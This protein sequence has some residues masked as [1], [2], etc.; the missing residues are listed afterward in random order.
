MPGTFKGSKFQVR[1][2]ALSY[3]WRVPG[4]RPR[5]RPFLSTLSRRQTSRKTS[6]TVLKVIISI[7]HSFNTGSPLR[8]SNFGLKN[9]K[10]RFPDKLFSMS[11]IVHLHKF[12]WISNEY[13]AS[14]MYKL[15][16]LYFL[17]K[18]FILP[19]VFPNS[20][21]GNSILL[22]IQAPNIVS[23]FS[24]LSQTTHIF[25]HQIYFLSFEKIFGIQPLFTFSTSIMLIS[26]LN[27]CNG[28]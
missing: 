23:S 26:L 19:I 25:H 5:T 2:R 11:F 1:H 27:Y 12:I 22:T 4:L 18:L 6:L 24:S 9:P 15:N 16:S 7:L 17:Q 3:R 14:N 21:N 28:L 20:V 8:N 13:P 10:F